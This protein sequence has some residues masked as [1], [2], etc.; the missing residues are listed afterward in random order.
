MHLTCEKFLAP[1][2][3]LEMD[4]DKAHG[5]RLVFNQRFQQ[6]EEKSV[7]C[8]FVTESNLGLLTAQ[9]DSNREMRCRGK[10]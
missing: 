4:A 2:V 8:S 9:Q 5:P 1:S 10:E 7:S 3:A 6:R